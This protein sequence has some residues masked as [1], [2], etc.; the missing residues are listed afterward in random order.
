MP[1]CSTLAIEANWVSGWVKLREYWMNACTSPRLR[2]PDDTRSPPITAIA[3]KL[4]LPRNI[5]AG[6][7][8][9]ERNWAP[10]PAW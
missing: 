10:N 6:W 7:I 1:D 9:P 4:R 2:R 5:I 8:V 3:T